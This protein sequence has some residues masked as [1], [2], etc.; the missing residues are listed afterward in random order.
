MSPWHG[1]GPGTP[2]SQPHRLRRQIPSSYGVSV[3]NQGRR[4]R[5]TKSLASE[6]DIGFFG[7]ADDRACRAFWAEPVNDDTS[8]FVAQPNS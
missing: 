5:F 4:S 8:V 7:A 2:D 6:S 3:D 1:S